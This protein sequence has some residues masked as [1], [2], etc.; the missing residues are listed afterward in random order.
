M[1]DVVLSR[2]GAACVLF[3]AASGAWCQASVPSESM[4]PRANAE[5]ANNQSTTPAQ[6]LVALRAIAAATL[7][8][9]EA[10]DLAAARKRVDDL[11][12]DWNR[13]APGLKSRAPDK[14]QSLDAAIDRAERELRFG[15]VRQTDSVMA[16][17]QVVAIIDS[18]K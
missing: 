7:Q 5:A 9:A 15:R 12:R 13:Q 11:E 2:S 6:D 8:M 3:A 14:W 17:R 4:K 18:I 10:G 16:L 1:R